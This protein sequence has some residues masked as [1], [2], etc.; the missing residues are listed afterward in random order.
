MAVKDLGGPVTLVERINALVRQFF[1]GNVF[2]AS[3]AWDVPQPTAHRLVAGQTGSPHAK[4]LG[5]IATFHGTTVEWLLTGTGGS[6]PLVGTPLPPVEWRS[7]R[8]VVEQLGLSPE[9]EWAVLS[10]P[11][12]I[13]G[14]YDT[15]CQW[16]LE[17]PKPLRPRDD[18]TTQA[19][20]DAFYRASALQYL[21][22]TTLLEGLVAAYGYPAVRKKLESEVWRARLGFHPIAMLLLQAP[23]GQRLLEQELGPRIRPQGRSGAPVTHTDTPQLP[24][25]DAAR[26]RTPRGRPRRAIPPSSRLEEPDED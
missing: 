13:F 23:D 15:L 8:R 14:A 19:A 21:S 4:T 6:D 26:V 20:R 9:A 22:W 2:Q 1:G 12:A 10:L 5:R 25:L 24:P 18:A 7:F 11:K 16:G 3:I 17:Y